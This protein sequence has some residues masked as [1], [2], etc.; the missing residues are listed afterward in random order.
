MKGKKKEKYLKIKKKIQRTK[1]YESWF[2]VER[3]RV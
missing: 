1:G 2:E 3:R